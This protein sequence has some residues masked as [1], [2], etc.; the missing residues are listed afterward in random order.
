MSRKKSLDWINAGEATYFPCI[1]GQRVTTMEEYYEH[2]DFCLTEKGEDYYSTII[3][4]LDTYLIALSEHQRGKHI[5]KMLNGNESWNTP[6]GPWG[7]TV[8]IDTRAS[9]QTITLVPQAGFEPAT[10]RA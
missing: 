7:M 8:R 6:A 9:E 5:E 3:A 4:A 2:R 1:C 10:H